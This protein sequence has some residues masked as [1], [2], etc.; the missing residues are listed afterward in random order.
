VA[1]LLVCPLNSHVIWRGHGVH[2]PISAPQFS[3]SI[4]VQ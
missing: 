4:R 1:R 3:P 2:P